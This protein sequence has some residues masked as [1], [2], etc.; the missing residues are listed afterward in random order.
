METFASHNIRLQNSGYENGKTIGEY[1][2]SDEYLR[3]FIT[4][5]MAEINQEA[6]IPKLQRFEREIAKYL[7]GFLDEI[8]GFEQVLFSVEIR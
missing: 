7:P 6:D 2:M 5:C 8:S 4:N 1:A 3:G